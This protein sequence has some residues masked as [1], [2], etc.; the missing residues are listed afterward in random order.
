MSTAG[1]NW[2]G[3]TQISE[4]IVRVLASKS[5]PS[6]VTWVGRVGRVEEILQILAV[7]AQKMAPNGQN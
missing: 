6:W 5:L 1:T 4:G 7:W 2:L 3:H